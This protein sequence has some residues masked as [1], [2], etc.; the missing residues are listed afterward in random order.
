M[1]RLRRGE[2]VRARLHRRNK[3]AT[4]TLLPHTHLKHTAP[5]LLN[6]EGIEDGCK[7][8]STMTF[9]RCAMSA[10]ELQVQA[11]REWSRSTE[12]QYR[13]HTFDYYWSERYARVYRLPVRIAPVGRQLH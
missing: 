7:S 6:M 12:L 4:I 2:A 8:P 1:R 13:Y 11:Y 10:T 9:R 3:T 5:R